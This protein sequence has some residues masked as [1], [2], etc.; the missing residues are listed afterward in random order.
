MLSLD[1]DDTIMAAAGHNAEAIVDEIVEKYKGNYILAVE[2]N[3]RIADFQSLT[4]EAQ[5]RDWLL[6]NEA[7]AAHL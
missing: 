6:H 4:G 3:D 5:L 7:L 2:G 1:Y